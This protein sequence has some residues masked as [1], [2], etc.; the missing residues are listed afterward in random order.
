MPIW[1]EYMKAA[2]PKSTDRPF[3]YSPLLQ[4]ASIDEATGRR[5]ESGGRRY[6]FLAGTAP[7]ATG[8]SAGQVS[9]DDLSTEL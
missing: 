3:D 7:E 6:P 1:M 8:F 9:L 5:V 2:A 4:W